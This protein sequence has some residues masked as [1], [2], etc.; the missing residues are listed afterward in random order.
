MKTWR[1]TV[2]INHQKGPVQVSMKGQERVSL[3]SLVDALN[4]L[5]I[6]NNHAYILFLMIKQ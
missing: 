6:T 4:S 2:A 1:A 3:V 5:S